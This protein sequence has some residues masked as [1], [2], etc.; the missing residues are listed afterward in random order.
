MKILIA[1]VLTLGLVSVSAVANEKI[2]LEQAAEILTLQNADKVKHAVASQIKR[3]IQ[4]SIHAMRV[5]VVQKMPIALLAKTEPQ[6][7]PATEVE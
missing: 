4:A 1:A 3:D 5:P 6:Y 7:Q 2:S